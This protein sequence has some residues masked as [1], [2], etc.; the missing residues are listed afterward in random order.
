MISPKINVPS[1][2]EPVRPWLLSVAAGVILLTVAGTHAQTSTNATTW[3]TADIG[4]GGFVT[5]TVFHPSEPNLVYARTDVGGVYRLDATNNRWIALNDDIGGL[6][7]EFQHQ[8]VLTIGLDPSDPNRLYIATGQYGGAESWKLPSRVYRSSNRGATWEGYVTPGFKM[9]GN[10]EG[11]GTGERMAVNPTDGNIILVG[12]S[13]QGV[14]RSTDRGVSWSRLAGFPSAITS[15]NFVI[16][17]A[18]N[19]SGPG[20]ARRVYAAGRTLTAASLWY[21]DNNGDTWTEVPNQP[22]RIAGQEMFA[23]MGSFDAAGIFYTTWG[24]QT[25]PNSFQ[26]RFV[27]SRMAASGFTWT[28]ITPPTGQGGFA[29]ISADP[30]VAGHVVCTTIHRWWPGDEVYRSTNSG[31]SWSAVLRSTGTTRSAGNSPWSADITPHWMTDIDIDPFD[32]NRVMFNTGFGLFQTTNLAAANSARV[33]TFFNDGLE[34]LVPLA[35]LSP[36]VGP[37]VVAAT[38]DYTGFRLDSLNQSPQRG[39]LSPRNGSNGA[40]SGAATN[41]ARMVRQ[42][43][44]DSLYSSDA[45]ASWTR[46]PNVPQSALNGHNRI[47]LSANGNTFLWAPV[48]SG[49][50]TSTNNG[51]TW[52]AAPGASVLIN[53]DARLSVSTLAGTLGTPGAANGTGTAATFTAP[54]GITIASDG[55]RYVADTGN[56]IIRKI[57]S[58]GDV[59]TLAGGAGTSGSTDATGTAARFNAPAGIVFANGNLYVADTGN[60]TIRKVTTAGVV[61]TFAG[62]AGA[63]GSANATGTAARFNAPRGL[64]ADSAGNLYVADT[65]N[66]TIRKITTA[67]VVTTLAGTAGSSGT[68]NGTGAA[69]RFNAPRGVAVDASGNVFVADTGNHCIRKITSA[70]V[71]TTFAGSAGTSGS[72]NGTTTAAR[73]NSPSGIAVDSS[74]IVHVADTGNQ[75]IRRITAAGS[76]STVAGTAGSTGTAGGDGT[77]ARF[78]TPSAVAVQADGYNLYVADTANHGIRR[79]SAYRTMNPVADAVDSNRLYLWNKDAR[80]LLTSTNAGAAFA[81]TTSALPSTLEQIRAVP[82]KT[83]NLWARANTDGMYVS[84]N[85]GS[86]WSKLSSVSAVYQFD[87]G[88]AAPGATH[89][90][91]FIWGTVGGVVGFY[92]SDNAGTSWTRINTNLQQFGYIND[93]AGDPRVYGRVYLGTSGRGVVY[94]ELAPSTPPASTASSLIYTDSLGSGWTNASTSGV[95]LTST[96]TVRRGTAAVSV[97]A[98]TSTNSYTFSLTTAARSTVGMAA[99]SFWV[100]SGSSSSPALRVGASR[101]GRALEAYPVT[102]PAGTGWRQVVVPLETLGLSNIDDLT[103]LRIEGYTLNGVLP[104]AFSVDDVALIG[105]NDYA[106]TP[107]ITLNGLSATYDGSPKPVTV[108]TSPAGLTTTVTYNGSPTVPSAR[109]EYAVVATLL[110]PFFTGSATGTL[111]ILDATSIQFTNLIAAADGTPKAPA[112]A[113]VPAG[114]AYAIT[115][116]G[117]ATAPSLAGQ[118]TVVATITEAGYVGSTSGTFTI[119]QATQAAT[120]LTG[121]TSGN[122]SSG[123]LTGKISGNSTASP[124]FT[125]NDTTDANSSNTLQARFAPVRLL[126]VGDTLTITGSF[127]LTVDGV[128]NAGNWLRFGLFDSNTQPA[129]TMTGWYGGASIGATYYERTSSTGLFTT[130]SGATA[131]MSDAS[132]TPIS[133]NSP[134]GR[135]PISFQATV[136]RT[137]SG[138]VH[139]FLVRRTDTNVTLISYSYTDTTP[140]NNGTLGSDATSLLNYS[141][142]YNVFALAF[143]R[144][145][146]GSP[147]PIA[148][149]Q[150]QFTNIQVAFTSGLNLTDQFITFPKPADRPVNST[151]FALSANA[152]SGLPVSLALVSGPAT[153]YGNTVTLTGVGAVT[154]R[155]TQPG[156]ATF[157]AAPAVEQTFVSTK[158]PGTVTLGNLTRTYTGSPLTPTATTSPSGRTVDYTFDGSPTVPTNAGSYNVTGTINDPN[159]S[160]EASGLFVIQT[161]NQSITFPAQGSR[162]VGVT[163]NPGATSSSGL[164]VTYSVVSGPAETD[165]SLVTVT[166]IGTVTLRAEQAG[167][168]NVQPA[169]SVE[170]TLATIQGTATVALGNLS[171]MYDGQPKPVTV[172]TTPAGLPIAVTYNG[173]SVPPTASGTYAVAAAVQDPNYTGS[174]TGTLTIAPRTAAAPVKGWRAGNTTT[175][176]D[177]NTSSP[178]LNATNG[179]GTNGA[180]T[181]FYAFFEPV[182]LANPGDTV[183][184]TGSTTVNAPGGTSGQGSWLRYGLYDNRNQSANITAAWLGYTAMANSSGAYSLYERTGNTGDFATTI[185]GVNPRT[186]DASP[187]YVGANSPSNAVTLNFEQ[188]ITRASNN[189]TVV[190]RLVRPGTNGGADT[191]YLSS[192]FTD[193]TPNNNGFITGDQTNALTPVHSPRY[194]AVGFVLSGAYIGTT[195]TSSVQFSNVQ[196]AFTAATDVAAPAITFDPLDD[197]PYTTNPITLSATSSSGLPVTFSVL[198]GPATVSSNALSLTGTGVVTVRASQ[199]GGLNTPDAT[200]VDRSFEVTRAEAAIELTGLTATFDGTEKS[201]QAAT[202]PAGLPVTITYDGQLSAPSSVGNYDVVATIDHELYMGTASATLA[203]TPPLSTWSDATTGTNLPWTEAAHWGTTAPPVS[204]RGATV[205]FFTG[206]NI[207]TGTITTLQNVAAPL[208]LHRLELNGFGPGSGQSLVRLTGQPLRLVPDGSSI[209]LIAA[210]A[211]AGSGLTYELAFDIESDS[212]LEFGGNGSAPLLVSGGI[213]G[214]GGLFIRTTAPVTLAGNALHLGPTSIAAGTLVVT[215]TVSGSASVTIGQ[216]ATLENRG[217]IETA[218]LTVMAGGRLA[219][220]GVI[221]GNVIILGDAFIDGPGAWRVEG[222]VTNTGTLRLTGGARLE[223]TGTL[224]NQGLLD[225]I[226]AGP[227]STTGTFVSSGHTATAETFRAPPQF[228]LEGSSA[229]ATFFAYEGHRFQLQ[230]RADLSQGTWDNVGTPVVGTGE[231]TSLTDPAPPSQGAFYRIIILPES[232]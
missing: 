152:S 71:V 217:V 169:T 229:R 104:P 15:I 87:F 47:A 123:S 25:G 222:N 4:G 99:L 70:G 221:R 179:S 223:V 208:S 185:Y 102:V 76:V 19:A 34:E 114:L 212:E 216:N 135:P 115:Y 55:N 124:L 31:A 213:S 125:P 59:A 184:I 228:A 226:T 126:N 39:T 141:P 168:E 147:T 97:P 36:S 159:Y 8:G 146:V 160:G 128:A 219:G 189:V 116:N 129:G 144:T 133:S 29:G 82:G 200:P 170:R 46:F 203:I 171:A 41:S 139:S 205:A 67:G 20:P 98:N 7:N 231:T 62:T 194:N 51:T 72:T 2:A 224:D 210:N 63:S 35:L 183:R 177:A 190:S 196:V 211:L 80:T 42:H 69:A 6:N 127:Q 75:T 49:A 156:N 209:P 22:G 100:S 61:T 30:R 53:A 130:G 195:N 10:G 5:G 33:W 176:A 113:T 26:S 56:H 101:G 103:G 182:T 164:P 157:D 174:A 163:F 38:G 24:D 187:A 90:A 11:R 143:G 175:V 188:T 109:G 162:G 218:T 73:F 40:L 17:A 140:N 111:R 64:A 23:V 16:Y 88:R 32:S 84:T 105:R 137:S 197:R 37:A 68:A 27:V 131:R 204:G 134:S 107:Q 58:G 145:Y 214:S 94:G 92:R 153:L 78:N 150:A 50:Y 192:T 136:T 230:R 225:L 9:A 206:A 77:A 148:G 14:W 138:V 66:H 198:S 178:L 93:M 74:G 151:P 57:A 1:T 121:W 86:A 154:I 13:D 132:P 186:P 166:G 173:S 3:R 12:T 191:I 79:T 149:L 110:D 142:T 52:T 172:T 193:T 122:S 158:I 91:V 65:G 155:A 202:T 117:S 44:E 215:G 119:R 112:V 207:P 83:T 85:G 28:T 227:G 95:S 161:A 45:G 108:T 18:A 120:D 181:A 165:G 60:Q 54:E 232:P 220:A 89:P 48:G 106:A 118:Y 201:V 81:V 43:S 96:N 180:A 21:S 199:T 167:N